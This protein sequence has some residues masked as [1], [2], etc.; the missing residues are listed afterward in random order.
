MT[1][2]SSCVTL[3]IRC[4]SVSM[5]RRKIVSATN[6]HEY[7]PIFFLISI[8]LYDSPAA[9]R[10][11]SCSFVAE[12]LLLLSDRF[13]ITIDRATVDPQNLGGS[14]FITVSLGEYQSH[15]AAFQFREGGT[16]VNERDA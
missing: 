3:R 2:T 14:R 10:E 7:T 4:S 5:S 16:I 15:I 6:E 11:H 8:P 1:E 12:T 13:Q 9:I